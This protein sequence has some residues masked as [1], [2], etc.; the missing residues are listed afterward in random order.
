MVTIELSEIEAHALAAILNSSE[1]RRVFRMKRS[2]SPLA[3]SLEQENPSEIVD[4]L[5]EAVQ[6]AILD[7]D[8]TSCGHGE[9][10]QGHSF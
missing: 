2:G 4:V 5:R 3:Y 8:A 6:D 10:C 1:I 7:V 9:T